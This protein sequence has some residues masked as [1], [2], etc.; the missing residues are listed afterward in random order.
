MLTIVNKDLDSWFK[1]K[2]SIMVQCF[3]QTFHYEADSDFLDFNLLPWLIA[4]VYRSSWIKK[5]LKTNNK[6]TLM[7]QTCKL[8]FLR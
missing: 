4:S 1:K 3:L 7:I 5:Y 8:A 2:T 6:R